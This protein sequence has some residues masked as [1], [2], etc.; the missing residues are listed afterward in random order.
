MVS[1]C[2][3]STSFIPGLVKARREF[4]SGITSDQFILDTVSYG[5]RIP[6]LDCPPS[7]APS[8]WSP[9]SPVQKEILSTEVNAL[10][11]R[12]IIVRREHELGE[13]VSP[14]WDMDGFCGP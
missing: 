13:L 12:G 6:F 11:Q 9:M 2:S 14:V 5:L 8:T 10:L 7:C 1:P 3:F 4:W